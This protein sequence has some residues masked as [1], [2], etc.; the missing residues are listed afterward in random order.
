MYLATFVGLAFGEVADR[1]APVSGV[2]F[3]LAAIAS[4]LCLAL[5]AFRRAEPVRPCRSAIST[6]Q[7]T[8]GQTAFATLLLASDA[9][10]G[11][12]LVSVIPQLLALLPFLLGL[13]YFVR[14]DAWLAAIGSAGFFATLVGM[15]LTNSG[16]GWVGFFYVY[17]T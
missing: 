7:I 3:L 4:I 9:Y 2:W 6:T 10:S 13:G 8:V 1:Y 15:L 17:C 5:A 11:V 14:R 16:G 12:N